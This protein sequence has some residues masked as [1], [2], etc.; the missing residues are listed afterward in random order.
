MLAGFFG[1]ALGVIPVGDVV[2]H[3]LVPSRHVDIF[4][5]LHSRIVVGILLGLSVL[6]LLPPYPWAKPRPSAESRQPAQS[7]VAGEQHRRGF[8]ELPN[9]DDDVQAAPPPQ[10]PLRVRP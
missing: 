6:W 2:L 10:L 7:A 1:A 8:R 5:A 9:Q 4:A 3:A